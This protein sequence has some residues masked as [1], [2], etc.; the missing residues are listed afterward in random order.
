MT[1]GNLSSAGFFPP[2]KR[3]RGE[4]ITLNGEGW[5]SGQPIALPE[6]DGKSKAKLDIVTP[7]NEWEYFYFKP[8]EMP[9]R[10]RSCE[11]VA[12]RYRGGNRI[13]LPGGNST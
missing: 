5:K 4:S 10:H 9:K 2:R 3:G 6:E 7:R 1:E 12:A 13:H 8:L 11:I